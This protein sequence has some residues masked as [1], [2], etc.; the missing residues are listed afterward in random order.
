MSEWNGTTR[1]Q[2]KGKYYWGAKPVAF[3]TTAASGSAGAHFEHQDWMGTERLRTAYNGGVEGMFTSL[4]WGD[5]PPSGTG[6]DL[7]ANHY[8]MLDHDNETDTDHAQFR[9]TPILRAAGS[10]RIRTEAATTFQ[11]SELQPLRLCDE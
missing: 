10:R 3:Y 2:L 6:S 1:A 4:P 7:D 8:A 9:S 5:G 11:P